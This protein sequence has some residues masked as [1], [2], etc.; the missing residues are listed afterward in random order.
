MKNRNLFKISVVSVFFFACIVSGA[1]LE[2]APVNPEFLQYSRSD[3]SDLE[4]PSPVSLPSAVYPSAPSSFDLRSY[5]RVSPVKDQ[6]TAGSCWAFATYASLESNL[7]PQENFDFS[8]NHMKNILSSYY[9]EGFDRKASDGGNQFMSTAYLVRWSGPV[10]ESMDPYNAS[11]TVSPANLQ[12]VKHIQEVVFVPDR[13][14]STDNNA[15]KQAVMNY[16]AIYTTMYYNNGFLARGKNYYY[17]GSN[18]S[19]HAVAIVGWNDSYS[20]TNFYGSAA[21]IPPGDG[22]FIVKNSWGTL[23][24]ESGYFYISYYDTNIGK[25]CV[26]FNNAEPTNNY[27]VMYQYD[28]LGWVTSAGFGSDTAHFA[29]IF[30]AK[31]TGTISAVG[32]YTPVANSQYEIKIYKNIYGKTPI[33]GNISMTKYGIISGAGYHTIKL[34]LDVGV[35]KNEKFSAVVRLKTPG[36]NYPIALEA[37]ISWYSSKASALPGES[38][39]SSD[40]ISWTDVTLSSP[41]TNICIKVYGSASALDI[42]SPDGGEVWEQGTTRTIAWKY[43]GNIK[44]RIKI[45]LLKDGSLACIIA[46][47]AALGTGGSGSFNWTIPATVS[48]GDSYKVRIT[49]TSNTSITDTSSTNFSI[50]GPAIIVDAPAKGLKLH[51]NSSQTIRW[52]YTGKISGFVRIELLQSGRIKKIITQACLIGTKGN[53]YYIWRIPSDIAPGDGYTVKVISNAMPKVYGTS[54]EFSILGPI[55]NIIAPGAGEK[56]FTNTTQTISWKYSGNPGSYVRIECLKGTSPIIISQKWLIGSS[57][58]G[59]YNWYIPSSYLAGS[60]YKIRITSTADRTVADTS[61]GTFTISPGSIT[62]ITPNGNETLMPGTRQRIVWSYEG[63]PGFWVAIELLKGSAVVLKIATIPIGS[64]GT[65]SYLWSIPSTL[66]IGSDYK[67][68]ITST[69]QTKVSDTSDGFFTISKVGAGFSIKAV[70]NE[71]FEESEYYK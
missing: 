62:I 40:G 22:A 32:F 43:T 68:R 12:P 16:G 34:A 21:G 56:W 14:S 25:N 52:R 31:Q 54:S 26:V 20:R 48:A 50:T 42:T 2:F 19:N 8:E 67:I 33:D 35:S 27:D 69:S 29:N 23:W 13:H 53:G 45:E 46:S 71:N 18:T 49:N 70:G 55:I 64:Y 9:S 39:V 10:F 28:P 38:F 57:G 44:G 1:S 59:S 66:K 41:G 17:K 47:S 30:T 63:K 58:T 51:K 11:S 65:G 15:I 4:I 3:V 36:Y 7:L 60:D 61:D 37:P 24:G 6:G 5:R